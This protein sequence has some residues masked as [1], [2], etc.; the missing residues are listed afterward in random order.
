MK[1]H[2]LNR[3]MEFIKAKYKCNSNTNQAHEMVF[4]EWAIWSERVKLQSQPELR[5]RCHYSL[6][7]AR[8]HA[9]ISHWRGFVTDNASSATEIPRVIGKTIVVESGADT[10]IA[11]IPNFQF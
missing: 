11:T 5:S 1:W 4:I 8:A 3:P 7:R 2:L 9:T 6:L 10:N